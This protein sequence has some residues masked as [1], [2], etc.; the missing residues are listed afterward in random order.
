M[1]PPRLTVEGPF[2]KYVDMTDYKIRLLIAQELYDEL[3][4]VLP[5]YYRLYMVESAQ[6]SVSI[7]DGNIMMGVITCA[8]AN[9]RICLLT[10]LEIIII[11]YVEPDFLDKVVTMVTDSIGRG[12]PV[13]SLE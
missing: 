7:V 2:H 13:K 3:R 6:E 11:D 10:S 12:S 5:G 4:A 1:A 8:S 9:I